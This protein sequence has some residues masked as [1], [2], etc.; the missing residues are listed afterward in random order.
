MDFK[1]IISDQVTAKLLII[2][3]IRGHLSLV[4]FRMIKKNGYSPSS[5]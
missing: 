5:L 3:K 4:T 2:S 1:K